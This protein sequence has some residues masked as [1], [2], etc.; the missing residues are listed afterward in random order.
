MENHAA[1]QILGSTQAPYLNHLVAAC[2]RAATYYAVSHP[3]LPNYLVL[4]SGSTHGVTDD[5]NPSAHPLG[6]PS[7]F[8]EVAATHRG[9]TTY[10]ES[11]PRSCYHLNSGE[12]VVRH[13]PATY[14]I[15]LRSTC[16][17]HDAALG[18]PTAGPFVTRLR[19]DRLSPFTMVV[20]NV[21]HDMHDCSVAT[22]DAW[23]RAMMSSI[24]SSRTYAAGGTAVFITWDEDNGAHGNQV[25]L[26]AVAPSIRPGTVA[27]GTFTHRS[28]LR[29]T[30]QLIGLPRTL[31]PT[32]PSMRTAFHI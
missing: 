6:G 4:T 31:V 18:T 8:T 2:G 11:M 7:I 28:L 12:Y 1:S 19:E 32:S 23:V 21:C 9:W 26:I 15:E 14:Y 20:P 16:V 24:L 10:A 25:A 13:N 3:S 5:A 22:G 30:E 27:G 29:T 17:W